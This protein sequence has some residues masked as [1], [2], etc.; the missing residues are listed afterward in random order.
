MSLASKVKITLKV[1][2]DELYNLDVPPEKED[3]HNFCLL[4]DNTLTEEDVSD[5]PRFRDEKD[6]ACDEP[7]GSKSLEFFTTYVDKGSKIVWRG[8]SV[9]KLLIEDSDDFINEDYDVTI[10]DIVPIQKA[11]TT[12]FFDKMVLRASCAGRIRGK[13][14]ESLGDEDLY[15]YQIVF[16]VHAEE[17]S[18][19]YSI[20]PKLR[21]KKY[22]RGNTGSQ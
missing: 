22:K 19:S 21:I 18:K 11:G 8:K 6:A 7:E 2:A 20:D 17:G 16:T 12:N 15:D 1:V 9:K 3:M 13:V 10:D 4:T 14:L 5:N